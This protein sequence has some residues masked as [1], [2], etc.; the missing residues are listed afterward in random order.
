VE[1]G[2]RIKVELSVPKS[3]RQFLKRRS[4][5]AVAGLEAAIL[6]ETHGFALAEE[7]GHVETD[8]EYDKNGAVLHGGEDVAEG[9]AEGVEEEV[10]EE[11][12]EGGAVQDEGGV[13]PEDSSVLKRQQLKTD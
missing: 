2:R 7:D 11:G 6:L 5:I 10:V 13:P 8:G 9:E 1:G 3:P 12:V 4:D